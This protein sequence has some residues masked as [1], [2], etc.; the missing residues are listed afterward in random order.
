MLETVNYAGK[1]G[2]CAF[3]HST[4]IA[5]SGPGLDARK[6]GVVGYVMLGI[7]FVGVVW[8]LL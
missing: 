2:D 3:F 5:S 1:N 6:G 8:G 7:G 4:E